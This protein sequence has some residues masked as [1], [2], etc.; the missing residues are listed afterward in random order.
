MII[1]KAGVIGS[2][3]LL[4]A[5]LALYVAGSASL[6]SMVLAGGLLLLMTVPA[7]RVFLAMAEW[8]R[9][10]DWPFVALTLIVLV[11]LAIALLLSTRRV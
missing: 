10:K 4:A 3:V 7:A 9:E 1:V 11:E 6:S 5:G 2:G 8:I